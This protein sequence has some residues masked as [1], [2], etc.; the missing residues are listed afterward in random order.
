MSFVPGTMRSWRTTPRSTAPRSICSARFP[1]ASSDPVHLDRST[2][3]RQSHVAYL[4]RATSCRLR[5]RDRLRIRVAPSAPPSHRPHRRRTVSTVGCS[6][7][8]SAI[9]G[10]CPRQQAR[11]CMAAPPSRCSR[12][13]RARSRRVGVDG[14][15]A[16]SREWSRPVDVIVRAWPLEWV[17]RTPLKRRRSTS[18]AGEAAALTNNWGISD[19]GARRPLAGEHDPGAQPRRRRVRQR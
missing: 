5:L 3:S 18:G 14:S 1:A 17:N 8:R 7:A 13:S 6:R 4:I 12:T 11:Q 2:Q 9:L 10:T 15:F 19:S 16:A